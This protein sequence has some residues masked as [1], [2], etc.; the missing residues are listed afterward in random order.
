VLILFLGCLTA[1]SIAG[2]AGRPKG[3]RHTVAGLVPRTLNCDSAAV[4]RALAADTARM[5]RSSQRFFPA[6]NSEG[7]HQTIYSD[8]QGPRVVSIVFLGETGRT[9]VTYFLGTPTSFFLQVDDER[10]A[11]PLSLASSPVVVSRD[12]HAGYVC[13]EK[14]RRSLADSAIVGWTTQLDSAIARAR[15]QHMR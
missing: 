4:M 3:I 9:R 15:S 2:S 11:K 12:V 8:R 14:V 1:L 13:A 6:E 10:Y 7:A 5:R